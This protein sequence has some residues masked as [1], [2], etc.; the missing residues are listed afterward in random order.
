MVNGKFRCLGSVQELKSK[1][2][3]G[4]HLSIQFDYM[5][6]RQ[7][8]EFV[9]KSFPRAVVEVE[10]EG[11]LQYKIPGDNI[12]LPRMFS[13]MEKNKEELRL[14]DYSISQQ[15]LEQVFLRFA[16]EQQKTDEMEERR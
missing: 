2:G 5:H 16:K 8:R 9:E 1:Y 15:T 12:S 13:L 10:I 6:T 11:L 4:Y 14:K 3:Q 7:V